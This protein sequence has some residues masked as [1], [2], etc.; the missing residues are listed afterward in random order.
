MLQKYPEYRRGIFCLCRAKNK[1]GHEVFDIFQ[2]LTY[3]VFILEV[4]A[5]RIRDRT[6]QTTIT[7][8]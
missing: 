1:K 6:S 3:R 5:T 8:P 7:S 4:T 2:K